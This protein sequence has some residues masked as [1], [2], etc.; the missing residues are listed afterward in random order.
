[1][2]VT[3]TECEYTI[4]RKLREAPEGMKVDHKCRSIKSGLRKRPKPEC[5]VYIP[6]I[7][8]NHGEDSIES[9]RLDNV[10]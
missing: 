9:S 5:I 3:P 4:G 2:K 10:Q 6:A 7:L 1:M 8:R